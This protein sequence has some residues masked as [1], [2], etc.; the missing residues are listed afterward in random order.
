[1]PRIPVSLP[2]PRVP[3]IRRMLD[4]RWLH[5]ID[6]SDR[7]RLAIATGLLVL[8]VVSA[9][10]TMRA[11][12]AAFSEEPAVEAA[13]AMPAPEVTGLAPKQRIRVRT[14]VQPVALQGKHLAPDMTVTISMPDARVATYGPEALSNV[15]STG[16]TLR[17]IFDVPGTYHVVF[18]TTA[19]VT[20]NEGTIAV[21]R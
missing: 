14:D 7:R 18:R 6:G 3:D 2:F 8:V 5:E 12:G 1:M 13:S 20:S 10:W 19:G 17:A 4:T 16:L 21:S 9:G 15:T 11:L